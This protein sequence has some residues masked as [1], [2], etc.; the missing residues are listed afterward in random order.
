MALTG[1][2]QQDRKTD[3]D[4]PSWTWEEKCYMVINEAVRGLRHSAWD[5]RHREKGKK[6]VLWFGNGV[7]SDSR[8]D[9]RF[10]KVEEIVVEPERL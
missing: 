1:S 4:S 2:I 9:E 5:R 6:L 3:S 8:A 7:G 10:E